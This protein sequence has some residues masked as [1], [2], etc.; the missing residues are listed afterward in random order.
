MAIDS[1]LHRSG[2]KLPLLQME[3]HAHDQ[4]F[5]NVD[6]DACVKFQKKGARPRTNSICGRWRMQGYQ[7][8]NRAG[9]TRACV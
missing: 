9:Q 1:A 5:V 7:A 2:S 4:R 6:A 3:A 8:S